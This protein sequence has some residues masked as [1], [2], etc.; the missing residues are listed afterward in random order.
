MDDPK[1]TFDLLLKTKQK[2]EKQY[3]QLARLAKNLKFF[4]QMKDILIMGIKAFPENKSMRLELAQSYANMM[5]KLQT[6]EQKTNYFNLAAEQYDYLI[7]HS[8]VDN[9]VYCNYGKLMC[10]FEDFTAAETYFKK[11]LEIKPDD[12][13]TRSAYKDMYCDF[14]RKLGQDFVRAEV[15]IKKALEIKEDDPKTHTE[16]GII[17]M[18]KGAHLDE[19]ERH[20]LRAIQLNKRFYKAHFHYSLLLLA[21][22]N[23]KDAKRHSELALE[24]CPAQL[25]DYIM[26][27]FKRMGKIE[28]KSHKIKD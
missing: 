6:K 13:I 12:V 24:Y 2:D 22:D 3:Q 11:S 16:Y 15:Y 23:K 28:G 26:D 20:F 19:A 4:E 5:R 18:Q 9:I 27:G 25:K 8:L 14:A 10:S 21:V 7:K 1:T 17:L